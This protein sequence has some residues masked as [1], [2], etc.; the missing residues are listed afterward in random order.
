MKKHY[1]LT[2]LMFVTGYVH[3]QDN[4][5]AIFGYKPKTILK[6]E[7]EH[8]KVF[9][10]DTTSLYHAFE[11]DAEA[12]NVLIYG[13]N[14]S[15][16]KTVKVENNETY[17]FMSIDPMSEKY[18][19]QSPY[20]YVLNNPIKYVDPD[21][22]EVWIS[23]GENQRAKYDNGKLYNEDGSK[24]KGKDSFVSNVSKYLNMMNKTE[25]GSSVLS[26]L[27][28][29]KNSFNFINQKPTSGATATFGPNSVI[30]PSGGTIKAGNLVGGRLDEMAKLDV[31]A[32]ELFHAYQNENK[33]FGP[34]V[35]NEVGGY[36]FGAGVVADY[37]D[38][39]R[40]GNF[41]TNSASGESYEKSMT[42]MLYG[43]YN[44]KQYNNAIQNFKTGSASNVPIPNHP[45]GTY[46]DFPVKPITTNPVIRNFSPY[47]R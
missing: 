46:A 40:A 36:L 44:Q 17:R 1:L 22:R 33:E 37:Q 7:P 19:D 27:S 43:G 12:K 20:N 32:H 18:Y 24:Y 14:G 29:S 25:I 26:S 42:S 23:Y 13:K 5:Y 34:S 31:V 16:L 38:G 6:D 47:I 35:N 21:G 15:I 45:N 28:S 3:A 8:L 10:K 39:M 30:N 2:L 9:N 41:G 4:P 11:F